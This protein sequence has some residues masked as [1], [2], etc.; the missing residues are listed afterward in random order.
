M[1]YFPIM[2]EQEFESR[3]PDLHVEVCDMLGMGFVP[4]IF[5]CL[6]HINPELALASWVMVKQNLCNGGLPRVTKEILF[7]YIAFRRNC[8]YCHMAHRAMALKFGYS[9][10]N[11]IDIIKDINSVRNPLLRSILKFGELCLKPDFN[12]KTQTYNELENLGLDKEDISELIG[13]VS[14]SL[15]MINMADSLVVDIDERFTDYTN[16]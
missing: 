10:Q 11:I 8:D 5:R 6:A 13:M 14:C 2:P 12:A 15:Y 4:N 1:D 16:R 9:E 7:S 3:Y